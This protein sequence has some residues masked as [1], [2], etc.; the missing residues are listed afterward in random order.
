MNTR[1]RLILIVA[2]LGIVTTVLVVALVQCTQS[3]DGTTVEHDISMATPE[4]TPTLTAGELLARELIQPRGQVTYS[5]D[6]CSKILETE[7]WCTVIKSAAPITRPE[8]EELLPQT[9]FFLVKTYLVS[10]GE[11]E[12][13]GGPRNWLIIEHDGQRY[14]A[15]TFDRLLKA[16]GVITITNENRELVAKAFALMTIPDY[17]EEEIVF[18]EWEKGDWPASFGERYNYRLTAWTR[19]LGLRPRWNFIFRDGRLREADGGVLEYQVGDY[20]DVPNLMPPSR[21]AFLY[22]DWGR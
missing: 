8:W 10:G 16:N 1:I 11:P 22:S 6:E 21:D 18:T 14:T 15:D 7:P 12:E 3:P 4:P 19:I 20:I 13:G 2:L 17:L 5:T 9:E